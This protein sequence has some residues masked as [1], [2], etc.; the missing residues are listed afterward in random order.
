MEANVDFDVA[1]KPDLRDT[2]N[3]DPVIH[4]SINKLE[5]LMYDLLSLRAALLPAVKASE[6]TG[7]SKAGVSFQHLKGFEHRNWSFQRVSTTRRKSEKVQL[8]GDPT[9]CPAQH[10]TTEGAVRVAIALNM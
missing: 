3:A 5:R 9:T 2:S 7:R 10:A 1:Q 6:S 4:L 8:I